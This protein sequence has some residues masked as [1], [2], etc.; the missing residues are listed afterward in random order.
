MA[1]PTFEENPFYGY[2]DEGMAV[3]EDHMGE[4]ALRFSLVALVFLIIAIVVV[5]KWVQYEGPLAA[6][7][8]AVYE[9]SPIL[10]QAEVDA[11][12]K[13]N[14]YSVVDAQNGRYTIPIER[15]MSIIAAEHAADKP[16]GE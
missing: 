8:N 5:I 7:Q 14:H 13:L 16:G 9:P 12:E 10:R 15:A 4:G 2:L 6:G 11:A 3:E 1:D